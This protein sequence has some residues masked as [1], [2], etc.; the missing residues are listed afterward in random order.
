MFDSSIFNR[1]IVASIIISCNSNLIS[2]RDSTSLSMIQTLLE[3]I[4]G[5]PISIRL[6]M[7]DLKYL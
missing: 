3:Y 5:L 6:V 7:D 2:Y 1:I 4:G